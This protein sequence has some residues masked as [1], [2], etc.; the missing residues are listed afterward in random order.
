MSSIRVKSSI[1]SLFLVFLFSQIAFGQSNVVFDKIQKS[2]STSN[3]ESISP[4][5]MDFVEIGWDE[6]KKTYDRKQSIV[7]L[8]EFLKKNPPISFEYIHKGS[9]KEGLLYSIGKYTS[10]Y[11]FW[12]LYILVKEVKGSFLIDTMDFSKE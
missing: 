10:E 8:K 11:G 12:R 1:G 7:V 9:S 4:L 6:T 2:I 3:V 5:M